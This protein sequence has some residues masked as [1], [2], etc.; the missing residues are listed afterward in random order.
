M[1][2]KLTWTIALAALSGSARGSASLERYYAHRT[3][4]DSNGVI[5][6]WHRGQNGQ[7]DERIRI[8]ADLYKRYPWV[9]TDKAAKAAPH[10]IYN[11]HWK[12]SPEGEIDIPP[13]DDWM[14]G[15]LGQRALSIIQGL[16]SHYA[17]SGD[18]LAFTYIP[19]TADYILDE[20][21]TGPDHPW[22]RFPVATPTR[23]KAYGRADPRVPNQLDLCATLGTEMVRAYKLIG[24]PRYFEA[25]RSWGETIAAHANLDPALPPWNRYVSPEFMAWSDELTGST[26]LIIDFLDALIDL[27]CRG[28][29]GSIEKARDAGLR[30]VREDLLPRWTE[31]DVWG[32]HYWDWE[33]PVM[34][35]LVPWSCETL[36]AHPDA[37]PGWKN[38][39]RN[40]LSL[41][42]NRNC[43]SPGSRGDAYSGAWAFPESSSCCGTSL[44]YNQYTY[45]PAFLRYAAEASDEWAREIGRRM[46]LMAAYDSLENGVVLDGLEG[47]VVAAGDW[48]NLAHPWPLCQ[49]L[50][51]MPYLPEVLAPQ[52]E[53][54]ILRTS[55]VVRS[56]VY[57]KGRISY[58]TFDA[59]PPNLDLL[60]LAFAPT[61]ISADGKSLPLRRDL[62]ENG[63]SLK[64]LA[65]GDCIVTIRHDG[66]RSILVEG[67]DPQEAAD[68]PVLSYA[69]EWAEVK[70][71]KAFGGGL[72]ASAA[73]GASATHAFT[74][75]QVRLVGAVG[76][77][78]GLADVF[79]DGA[80]GLAP[81]DFWS[82]EPRWEQTLYSRSGLTNGRHEIKVSARGARNLISQGNRIAIDLF[83]TSK[84][85]AEPEFGEGGGP[86]TAQRMIFGFTSRKD[87][88]DS[89]G[90]R[91]RP[92][93][94]FVVRSGD[95]ADSIATSWWTHRRS[96]T[97]GK[98]PDPEL[99]RY[100]AH[101]KEF[102]VNLTV[103]PGLYDLRLLFADTNTGSVVT[104]WINGKEV[105]KEMDIAREAGGKFQAL[106]R[107]F[108]GIAPRSGMIEVRLAGSGGKEASL[109]A[110]E[111]V[112][113]EK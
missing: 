76:P 50:K 108:P 75:N 99:Y 16:T 79:L 104:A 21:L 43:V 57:G 97:I 78:G 85:E 24:N 91:W 19:L 105:L 6:P 23:G 3:A 81:V 112:P 29:G 65:C 113:R 103:G 72:H 89:K 9:G 53:N 93:T 7:L 27:G 62:T 28:P 13:T 66:A 87:Y 86:R 51:A 64:F 52:R 102:W 55:S 100:G 98:T 40:I 32:R 1:F 90:N 31:N 101:G 80:K 95:G 26:T 82:P 56:V 77:D 54:H 35:G 22:P 111:L 2:R 39:V 11:T 33:N 5:A 48:L 18:P 83:L 15:D 68:D 73:S 12:I 47:K 20:C 110:L 25:A 17:Y 42:F 4:E 94:E 88:V 67:D 30:Y 36:M 74:G 109:Q 96:M 37:F 92:G 61:A 45:G 84:A 106:D 46:M 60:R 34:C 71:A 49:A 70:D 38:D 59:K 69:G 58:S 41:I 10:I 8:A 107:T 44:S 63:Y 14:C